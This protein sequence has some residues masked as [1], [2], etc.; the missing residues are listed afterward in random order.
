MTAQPITMQRA[1]GVAR[2]GFAMK[3]GES[4][5][6][7]L[8][9]AGCLKLMLPQTHIPTPQAVMINTAGGLTGGDR[10][11]L[12][13]D[14]GPGAAL[15]LATQPAERIYRSTGDAARVDLRFRV[16]NGARF[17][18]LAQE[19]IL[20]NHGHVR[21]S[22]TAKLDT[23]ASLLVVEP[24]VLGRQ[25]M[26]EAVQNGL[27]HDQWRI[28]Q[29]GR[30]I[31]VDATKLSNFTDLQADA[32]MGDATALATILLVTPDTA[33]KRAQILPV[34]EWDTVTAGASAWDDMLIIRALSHNAQ[35]LRDMIKHTIVTLRGDPL[36]RVWT[37]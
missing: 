18:W 9:Q 14:V 19:T 25:A 15:Q 37:M 12:D 2:L 27:L 23:N 32:A 7:D 30:L 13:V 31:F 22:I 17:D 20:F 4:R 10:L 28:W 3:N 6:H 33:A 29:N 1:R 5:L 11:N 8:H 24:I 26:G 34:L 21:R 16:G 35:Q 36:P